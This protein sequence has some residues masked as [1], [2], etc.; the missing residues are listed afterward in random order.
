ML[1]MMTGVTTESEARESARQWLAAWNSH[2]LDGIM[3][4][5]DAAA[6]LTSPVAAKILNNPS[7]TVEGTGVAQLL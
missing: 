1:R 7:E 6:V 2:D 5:Y 3:S 4:H